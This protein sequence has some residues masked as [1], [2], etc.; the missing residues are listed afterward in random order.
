MVLLLIPASGPKSQLE[1]PHLFDSLARSRGAILWRARRALDREDAAG[2]LV[3]KHG[4]ETKHQFNRVPVQQFGFILHLFF[5]HSR[6]FEIL[7]QT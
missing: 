3:I 2:P 7:A 4:N 6:R 5:G 1:S